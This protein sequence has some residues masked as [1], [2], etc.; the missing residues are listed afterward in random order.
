M[1][2]T[3]PHAKERMNERN[4][5]EEEVEY[6]IENGER[7][8]AKYGRFGFR[9][10]FIFEEIWKGNFYST[11]QVEIFVEK[12]ENNLIVVSVISKFF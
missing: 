12:E 1:I 10:N 2:K 3:I 8:L 11:K 4:I 6:T 7:F 5:S 9:C